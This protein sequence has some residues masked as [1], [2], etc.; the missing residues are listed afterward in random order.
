MPMRTRALALG[1]TTLLT[2]TLVATTGL[3]AGGGAAAAADP[4]PPLD[5]GP[6][7]LV[8][9]RVTEEIRPGVTWTRITRGERDERPAWVV[10]VSVPSA[11]T[12]PDPDAPARAI[13]DE[14]A[15]REHAAAV[16]AAGHPASA[17]P[18]AHP[19]T[20]DVPAG[21]IGWRVRLDAPFATV[22]D[23]SAVVA[24]LRTAGITSRAWYEGWDGDS[25]ARGPWQVDVVTI[26]PGAFDGELGA[27]FGPDIETR[28][29]PSALARATGAAV[30]VNASYFVL[31]PRIG[32]PGDP[33][34]AG[35]YDGV[36]QSEPVGGRPVL[37]LD[38][39]GRTSEV[40]RPSW[41]GVLTFAAGRRRIDGINRV[42]GRIRGCGGTFDD[43]PTSL[44]LH[45]VTCTDA[46]ELVVFT[47][48]FGPSTPSGP[49]AEAVL[50]RYGRVVSVA[51]ARGTTLA[52]GQRSIQ[53]TG[54]AVPTLT[55]LR[56]GDKVA[57]Q[58]YL[59]SGSR[60]LTGAG[61]SV[62]GGGPELVRDGQVHVTQRQDGM[63]HPG[64][65]SFAYG[66]VVQRNPRTVAGVDARGRTMLVTIDGRRPD[67]LGASLVE[68][69]A[70]ARSL[71]MVDALNLDGGGST[72]MT[73]RGRLVSTP[74]DA[75]GERPVGDVVY[76]R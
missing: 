62:V 7:G 73:V 53:A 39:G 28:E 74:S 13:Q 23:A 5:L 56:P 24:R 6:P 38:P 30:T 63:L 29:S 32:A 22:E 14:A 59:R 65:P 26:D 10:E 37:A 20:A 2:L 64:N 25:S 51:G 3:G 11:G 49:G 47:T 9:E 70:V 12:S 35:V 31:D 45:D 42:P 15:A 66:W 69:A 48:A 71:G 76:V 4:P 18:V 43:L 52:P 33:T 50:D 67:R 61:R 21:E 34:G 72:A 75:A 60:H 16:T 8:E 41:Y 57:Q 27:T 40:V 17:E 36:V 19:A 68:A 1:T 46:D 44:P 54:R 55:G 58:T